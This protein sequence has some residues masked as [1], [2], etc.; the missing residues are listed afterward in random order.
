MIFP[1]PAALLNL[2]QAKGRLFNLWSREQFRLIFA[3]VFSVPDF[4]LPS[5]AWEGRETSLQ[6]VSRG[7]LGH[8]FAA[9]GASFL[10][11]GPSPTRL[12][13]STLPKLRLERVKSKI[14]ANPTERQYR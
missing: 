12:R 5:E 1:T 14:C 4:T 7:G 8:R 13:P 10:V 9:I 3:E 2:A 6:R 11:L